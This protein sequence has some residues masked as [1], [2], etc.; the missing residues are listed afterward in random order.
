MGRFGAGTPQVLVP[1]SPGF[2][3]CGF[4]SFSIKE[5]QIL[6]LSLHSLALLPCFTQGI[7]GVG[8]DQKSQAGTS[9]GRSGRGDKEWRLSGCQGR[10]CLQ[11]KT[12]VGRAG[13]ILWE[14]QPRQSLS[15]GRFSSTEPPLVSSG[16][17]QGNLKPFWVKLEKE[18]QRFIPN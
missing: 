5:D 10:P 16:G 14:K 12:W 15:L 13:R 4:C 6:S 11:G 9:K 1:S 2:I 17:G 18:W 7:V 8:R 3:R